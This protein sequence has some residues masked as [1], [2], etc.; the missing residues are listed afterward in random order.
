MLNQNVAKYKTSG[1]TDWSSTYTTTPSDQPFH[2]TL[3][4]GWLQKQQLQ[5]PVD[6]VAFLWSQ[7]FQRS[8]ML[9]FNSQEFLE[10]SGYK[11]NNDGISIH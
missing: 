6:Q 3:Q 1:A 8:G 4:N 5:A 11:R 10:A 2:P 9:F 7:L